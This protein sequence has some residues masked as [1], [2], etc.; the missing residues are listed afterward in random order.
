MWPENKGR[1]NLGQIGQIPLTCSFTLFLGNKVMVYAVC[2]TIMRCKLRSVSAVLFYSNI[3]LILNIFQLR[4]KLSH[5]GC[6][7]GL[8]SLEQNHLPSVSQPIPD[9]VLCLEN[10]PEYQ[11]PL[12]S[13]SHL[14]AMGFHC[15]SSEMLLFLN[16]QIADSANLC[17]LAPEQLWKR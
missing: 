12:C 4:R 6:V 16:I 10:I 7:L 2:A 9:V 3:P 1:E 17:P 8:S 15:R 13:V 14:P 5:F 11:Q